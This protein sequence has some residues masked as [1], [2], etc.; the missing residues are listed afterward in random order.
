MHKS[1]VVATLKFIFCRLKI[2]TI[3][4]FVYR[5]ASLYD[6]CLL[7]S[8][9]CPHWI[10]KCLKFLK[11]SRSIENISMRFLKDSRSM[12]FVTKASKLIGAKL[13]AEQQRLIA[14]LTKVSCR[15][16]LLCYCNHPLFSSTK[17]LST[18]YFSVTS[19]FPEISIFNKSKIAFQ[20]F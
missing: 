18:K 6:L 10:L 8:S 4:P 5:W 19:R 3:Q 14:Q 2:K 16:S 11:V 13:R 1:I 9:W 20:I 17:L 7:C 15:K 12:V